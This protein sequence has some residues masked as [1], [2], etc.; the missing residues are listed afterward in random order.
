L[1]A[2]LFCWCAGEYFIGCAKRNRDDG[3]FGWHQIIN[4]QYKPL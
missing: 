1:P 3:A 4:T 2:F